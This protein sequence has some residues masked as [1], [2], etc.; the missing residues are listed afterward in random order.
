MPQGLTATQ[1]ISTCAREFDVAWQSWAAPHREPR[2]PAENASGVQRFR[3]SRRV[4]LPLAGYG[5]AA[6][7][8]PLEHENQG[9]RAPIGD[10]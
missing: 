7:P 6:S 2:C 10:S 1:S 3:T 8:T 9:G 5:D 4:F